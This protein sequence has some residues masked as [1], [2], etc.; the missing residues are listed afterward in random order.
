MS[1]VELSETLGELK[2]S[3]YWDLTLVVFLLICFLSVGLIITRFAW[4]V[5]GILRLLFLGLLCFLDGFVL[6]HLLHLLNNLGR[7]IIDDG[8]VHL[9][10]LLQGLLLDNLRLLS[11]VCLNILSVNVLSLPQSPVKNSS[12]INRR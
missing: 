6:H 8:G 4:T 2:E 12:G 10:V 11:G 5:L 7:T 3:K 1:F 9:L